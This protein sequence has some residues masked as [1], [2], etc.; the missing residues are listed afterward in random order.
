MS[1]KLGWQMDK[2]LIV[3][4]EIDICMLL[5]AQLQKLGF[6]PSFCLSIKEANEK[7]SM[8]TYDIVFV[9]LNLPDGSGY[10]LIYSLRTIDK[11]V[12]IVVISA[13][14]AE[15]QKVMEA[16]ASLYIPKPFT[17]NSIRAALKELNFT[18]N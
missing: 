14:E 7:L 10:D 6:H 1:G 2:A 11:T 13:Y 16:G 5:A 9:D 18:G 17:G 12:K 15:R 3:D 8:T 4:D